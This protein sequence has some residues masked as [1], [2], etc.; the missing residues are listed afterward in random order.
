M[1]GG[2]SIDRIALKVYE[3]GP[4]WLQNFMC[5]IEGWRIMNRR[6]NGAF[7]QTLEFLNES[8]WWSYQ[9]SREYQNTQL[10][11]LVTHSFE[12]VPF[13]R[14]LFNK[15]GLSPS[16]IQCAEDLNKLPIL[17]KEEVISAGNDIISR[18]HATRY[19]RYGYTSGTTGTS[20]RMTYLPESESFQWAVWWRHRNRFGLVFGDPHVQFTARHIVP[21]NQQSPP[22]WR[23]S[24]PLNQLRVSLAHMTPSNLPAIVEYL[25]TGGW[26]YYAGYPSAVYVV[27]DFMRSVGRPLRNGPEFFVSGAESLLPF[28]EKTISEWIGCRVID[29]YGLAEGA[30]NISQCENGTY[31]VDMEFGIVEEG[32]LV[33]ESGHARSSKIIGTTLQN[34]AMPLIRYDTGDIMTVSDRKCNCGRQSPVVDNIDGRIES[35]VITPSGHRLGRLMTVFKELTSVREAQILQERIDAITVRIVRR[36]EYGQKDQEKLVAELRK[37][38][39]E[40]LD[41]RLLYVDDISRSPGGK[42]RAVVSTIAK[43]IIGDPLGRCEQRD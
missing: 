32:D 22:Y 42:Y 4:A 16:D 25:E 2:L 43:G 23:H 3:N 36:P 33:S 1:G 5:G 39:G 10:R 26:R 27:A 18:N 20:L 34:W 15:L 12:N 17:T 14:R 28:Q 29:Q 7:H 38:V 30:A 24:H 40:E 13:Y 21:I 37:R 35:Y 6:F 11:N 8:Q 9:S 31:H 41:I 19:L